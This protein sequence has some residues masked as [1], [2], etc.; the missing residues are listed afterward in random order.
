MWMLHPYCGKLEGEIMSVREGHVLMPCSASCRRPCTC[1]S[2][3]TSPQVIG[4]RM[5]WRLGRHSTF[6]TPMLP[7]RKPQANLAPTQCQYESESPKASTESKVP[8]NPHFNTATL[9]R[10]QH[11][12][13]VFV[14]FVVA[15]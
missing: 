13:V 5:E 10:M 4:W 6:A 9:P 8:V 7:L 3:D 2:E 15:Q 14:S 12:V 1:Q 11:I